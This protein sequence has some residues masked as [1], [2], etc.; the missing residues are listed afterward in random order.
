MA[1]NEKEAYDELV[2][3]LERTSADV[4]DLAQY[5]LDYAARMNRQIHALRT[6]FDRLLERQTRL[7]REQSDLHT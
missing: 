3:R 4:K 1:V 2:E 7:I 5:V 6:D